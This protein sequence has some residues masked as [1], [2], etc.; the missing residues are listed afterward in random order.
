MR[1]VLLDVSYIVCV[2]SGRWGLTDWGPEGQGGRKP[3]GRALRQAV[4]NTASPKVSTHRHPLGPHPH[5]QRDTL[6]R[7]PGTT[8]VLSRPH[9]RADLAAG[10]YLAKKL[11]WNQGAH[12]SRKAGGHLGGEPGLG[13]E[14]GNS[15]E[16][17]AYYVPGPFLGA[18]LGLTR[19]SHTPC[20]KVGVTPEAEMREQERGGPASPSPKV[21]AS[22]VSDSLQFYGL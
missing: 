6:E 3:R 7:R 12:P 13:S 14:Q 2:L 11:R 17:R 8:Q 22:V 21:S 1:S 16:P 10:W 20:G 18:F 9:Q 15:P 5:K 4:P 19:S